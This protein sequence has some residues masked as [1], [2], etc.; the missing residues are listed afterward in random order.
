MQLERVTPLNERAVLSY[1]ARDPYAN[2]FITHLIGA[3]FSASTRAKLVA[4]RN[5][6]DTVAG[7][8]YFGQ[9]LMIVGDD[10]ALP[11][12]AERARRYRGERMIFGPRDTVRAFWQLVE[13][14]HARPRVVRDRQL[15]MV[16]DRARLR[17]YE[18]T[19]TV[20][21]AQMNEWTA[22]A[23]ASAQMIA[24]ELDYDPRRIS[25]DYAAN[26]QRMID[27]KLWWVGVSY[28][29]LCFFCNIGPWCRQTAQ[30]QGIWTPPELRGR[31]L[32]TASLAAICDRLL[33][34]TPTLSLYVNDFN[35]AAIALYRRVG[36]EHVSDF[37]T[38]LF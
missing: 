33:A 5:R 18:R 17:P 13:G 32:A 31:G 36:F 7:V 26:I 11:A 23:D 29:R 12:F 24:H 25:G 22:V 8:A 35:Q 21:H 16:V 3:D 37:Q 20:R 4:A 28:Q 1:L 19:V 14:W 30:L 34:D 9:Q 6:D 2:V 10:D 27:R 38:L 15:V